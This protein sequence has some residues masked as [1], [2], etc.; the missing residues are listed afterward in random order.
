MLKRIEKI[1]RNTLVKTTFRVARPSDEFILRETD[2]GT[3]NIETE[4]IRQ[5]VKRTNI[6]GVHEI[7][8][9]I[10]YAPTA[11]TPLQIKFNLIILQNYSAPILGGNLRDAIKEELKNWLDIRDALF[12]IRV[13]QI[14]QNLPEPKRRRVR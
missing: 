9:I 8:N 11:N 14:S 12:D 6:E 3:I 10:I 7:N 1:F 5:I 2:F 4:V 13:T